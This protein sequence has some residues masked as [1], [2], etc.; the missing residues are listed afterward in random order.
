MDLRTS[1]KTYCSLLK[2]FLNNKKYRVF[3]HF[4]IITNILLILKKG[5]IFPTSFFLA[6]WP[7]DGPGMRPAD[8]SR[9]SGSSLSSA[10]LRGWLQ[11][12]WGVM[13]RMGLEAMV[14][15]A[16][17]WSG[18]VGFHFGALGL[19][20][21]QSGFGPFRAVVGEG[22]WGASGLCPK[23]S[24]RAL[25]SEVYPAGKL[26]WHFTCGFNFSLWLPFV[27][28]FAVLKGLNLRTLV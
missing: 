21:A 13:V 4:F 11:A 14:W 6:V 17:A 2:T 16:F 27:G 26:Q 23:F 12:L 5:L 15:A 1:S 18:F 24:S 28:G 3:H 20:A 19:V 9:G 22:E 8:S 25:P 10:C 7:I